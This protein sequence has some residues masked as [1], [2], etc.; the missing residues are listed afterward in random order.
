MR[1]ESEKLN[2]AFDRSRSRFV[3][4]NIGLAVGLVLAGAIE[5]C[6]MLLR[7]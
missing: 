3:C 2:R 6:I 4:L 7:E 1:E 5:I